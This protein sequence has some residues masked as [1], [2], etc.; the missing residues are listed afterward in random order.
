MRTIDMG[1]LNDDVIDFTG[2]SEKDEILTLI[3]SDQ[4]YWDDREELAK[5]HAEILTDKINAYVGYIFS[6]QILEDFKDVVVKKVCIEI[7]QPGEFNPYGK[8]FFQDIQNF[9]AEHNIEI[10][11]RIP[12][13]NAL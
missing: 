1:I 4:Y 12:S 5:A 6:E 11:Y 8:A 7:V 2:Y 3:I 10:T 9:L 13:Q